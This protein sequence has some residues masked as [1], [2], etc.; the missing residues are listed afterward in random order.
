MWLAQ[1]HYYIVININSSIITIIIAIIIIKERVL[2]L[3]SI[4]FFPFSVSDHF[5]LCCDSFFQPWLNSSTLCSFILHCMPSSPLWF[6]SYAW[7]HFPF[8]YFCVPWGIINLSAKYVFIFLELCRHVHNVGKLADR[9]RKYTY[10]DISFWSS[11][12]YSTLHI[13]PIL[14]KLCHNFSSFLF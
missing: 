2:S 13:P 5:L 12:Q 14:I 3:L 8:C 4:T 7:K 10:T 9:G 11:V 1:R 6:P